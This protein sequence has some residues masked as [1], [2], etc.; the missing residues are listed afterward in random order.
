MTSLT[1]SSRLLASRKKPDPQTGGREGERGMRSGRLGQLVAVH[2][3]MLVEAG[4]GNAG[5]GRR[6]Q[7]RAMA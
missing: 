5:G 2:N 4:D 7:A 1:L 3:G 6:F